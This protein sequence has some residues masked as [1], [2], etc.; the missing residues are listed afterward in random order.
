VLSQLES[1]DAVT[2]RKRTRARPAD[3]GARHSFSRQGEPEL[4]KRL[5]RFE[6]LAAMLVAVA[7]GGVAFVAGRTL[8]RVHD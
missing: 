3:A 2:W 8:Q 4:F 5:I 6:M 7:I 1:R